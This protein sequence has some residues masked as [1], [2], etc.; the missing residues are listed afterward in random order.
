MLYRIRT[1]SLALVGLCWACS[2]DQKTT[3]SPADTSHEQMPSNVDSAMETAPETGGSGNA[4]P[5]SPPPQS[6]N[7]TGSGNA[8]A[9]GTTAERADD[10]QLGQDQI[11]QITRLANDAEIQQAKLAQSKAQKVEVKQ[12][13]SLMVS[14]HTQAKN[15]EAELCRK[16]DLTPEPSPKSNLLESE[17]NKVLGRLR[18][19]DGA[20]FDQAYIDAQVQE[21]K[22]VLDMLDQHLIPAAKAPELSDSLKKMRSMVAGHLQR[23]Q[24]IQSELKATH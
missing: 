9:T 18:G 14:D 10:A 6:S 4:P 16:L 2:S 22:E 11:V 24:T 13:A 1:F 15:S 20:A 23:A 3:S 7:N 19:A 8:L 5:N 17:T 21:H 12:F